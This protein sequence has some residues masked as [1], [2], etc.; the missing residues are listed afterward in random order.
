MVGKVSKDR[1]IITLTNTNSLLVFDSHETLFTVTR[2]LI[3]VLNDVE[4]EYQIWHH[5]D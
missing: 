4:D 2:F 5:Y 3:R 1:K